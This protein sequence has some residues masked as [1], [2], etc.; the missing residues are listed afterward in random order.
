MYGQ[1]MVDCLERT[2]DGNAEKCSK[3]QPQKKIIG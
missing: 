3:M 1:K 2:N